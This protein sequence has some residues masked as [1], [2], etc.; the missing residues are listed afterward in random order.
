VPKLWLTLG[1]SL[2]IAVL[3]GCGG[4]STVGDTPAEAAT[5]QSHSAVTAKRKG[6]KLRVV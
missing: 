5:T 6:P 2:V 4:S 1:A 3:A